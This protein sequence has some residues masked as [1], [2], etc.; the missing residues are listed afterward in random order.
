MLI[1][2]HWSVTIISDLSF[3]IIGDISW[4]INSR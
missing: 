4:L 2:N 1:T 3:Q